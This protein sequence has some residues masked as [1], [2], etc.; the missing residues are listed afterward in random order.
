MMHIFQLYR[1]EE[2][3]WCIWAKNETSVKKYKFFQTVAIFIA[4][5]S[6]HTQKN[7]DH[8]PS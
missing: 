6:L 4:Y 2:L 1:S 5:V 8:Q 7:S 3:E